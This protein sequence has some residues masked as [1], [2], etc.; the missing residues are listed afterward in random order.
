MPSVYSNIGTGETDWYTKSETIYSGAGTGETD[1]HTKSEIIY[2]GAGTGETLW[3]PIELNILGIS[4]TTVW[5]DG[6]TEAVEVEFEITSPA[7]STVPFAIE[8]KETLED[9]APTNQIITRTIPGDGGTLKVTVDETIFTYEIIKEDK[10][11]LKAVRRFKYDKSH[12]RNGVTMIPGTGYTGEGYAIMKL[13][14]ARRFG[15]VGNKVTS[16]GEETI[17]QTVTKE[18]EV[19]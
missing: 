7:E 3:P 6:T 5:D 18:M 8:L 13:H 15:I 4:P 1:W 19:F 2:S 12:T 9:S 14:T 10:D 16:T 17:V 11:T